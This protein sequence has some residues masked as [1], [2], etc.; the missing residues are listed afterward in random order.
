MSKNLGWYFYKD[1]YRGLDIVAQDKK[2]LQEQAK[3][4]HQRNDTFLLRKWSDMDN[5]A[6]IL[7]RSRAAANVCLKLC[8]TYPGMLMG[9][10]YAHG[11]KQEGEFKIGFY[12]DHVT[13]MPLLP[14]SSVKGSL[15]QAFSSPARNYL[16]TLLRQ[17]LHQ[18][19]FELS[20]PLR[21]LLA[22]HIFGPEQGKTESKPVGNV[23]QQDVFLDAFPIK[24]KHNKGYFL[25]SDSITPHPDP[26]RNP[27]PLLFLKVLPGVTFWFGF[28]LH[29]TRIELEDGSVFELT[30]AH[31][32][33][34]FRRILYDLGVGAKTNVGYGQFD[35]AQEDLSPEPGTLDT[36]SVASTDKAI[37]EP[38]FYPGTISPNEPNVVLDA[39]VTHNSSK[40]FRANLYLTEGTILE[41]KVEKVPSEGLQIGTTIQVI[42]GFINGK[43]FSVNFKSIKD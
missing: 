18:E 14:G 24:T 39:V 3:S 4:Y 36:L 9:T 43:P 35:P 13:G 37:I 27:I 7:D 1:Y 41:Y 21:A 20:E 11:V 38:A 6:Q 2:F 29:P 31:K 33:D 12:F 42:V 17:V 8:T 25:G 10:G 34:L 22:L 32:K 40:P 16:Q 15:R 23:Y 30:V 5:A 28:R 26:L 19:N